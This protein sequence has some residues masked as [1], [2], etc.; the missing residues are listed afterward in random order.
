MKISYKSI[1]YI[2]CFSS[3]I[4]CNN[5]NGLQISK[6]DI[7]RAGT[8]T[9]QYPS[10]LSSNLNEDNHII[11][12]K[13]QNKYEGLYYGTSDEFDIARENYLP[14][15]FVLK[16]DD[17][18]ING[19]TIVF[20]LS[21]Q[22]NDFFKESISTSI[23]SSQDAAKKCYI[24]WGKFDNYPFITPKKYRGLFSDSKTIFFEKD[25]YNGMFEKQFIKE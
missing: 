6:K 22:K 21:S 15:Y 25:S 12:Q 19:D 5:V 24:L 11:I 18:Y 2:L 16:M 1:F 8:Y 20:T 7:N 9:W 4:Q 10:E 17:L 3:F 14:G 13:R 23:R